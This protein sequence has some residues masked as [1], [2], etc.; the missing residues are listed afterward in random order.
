M[1]NSIFYSFVCIWWSILLRRTTWCTV[2][3]APDRRTTAALF[4]LPNWRIVSSSQLVAVCNWCDHY[5]FWL[6]LTECQHFVVSAILL[7]RSQLLPVWN[8]WQWVM[9]ASA[10]SCWLYLFVMSAIGGAKQYW[11]SLP[12]VC[13]WR[14]VTT[15]AQQHWPVCNWMRLSQRLAELAHGFN[16]FATS[17]IDGIKQYQV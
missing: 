3:D 10:T 8:L 1:L 17:A 9:M 4:G 7:T 14:I 15:P 2:S 5:E 11:V 13:N 6:K 12:N 16:L